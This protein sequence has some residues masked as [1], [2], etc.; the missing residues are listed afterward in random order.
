MDKSGQC[1]LVHAALRCHPDI[2]H[3][4][5]EL[6]W[7]PEGQQQNC[8]LK[9][10]T[11]QQ[12]LIAASSMGHTQVSQKTL[13]ESQMAHVATTQFTAQGLYGHLNPRKVMELENSFPG[14]EKYGCAR[15]Q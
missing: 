12:A 1:A 7:T 13:V 5:L 10:K 2:I 3:H 14:L 4:L 9:N 6:E 11:L 15:S 8:S